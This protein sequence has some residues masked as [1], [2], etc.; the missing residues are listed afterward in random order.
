MSLPEDQVRG[1]ETH[2]I[3]LER[4]Y[5]LIEEHRGAGRLDA[6][7]HIAHQ[8][9][10]ARPGEAR[11]THY[12]GILAHQRGQ[13]G[14]AIEKVQR[15]VALAPDVALFR[16]NL[17]EMYRLAGK[18]DL[19][20]QQGERAVELQPDYAEALSN[21]G[22]AYYERKDYQEALSCQQRAV[23]LK[24]DFGKGHMNLGNALHALR[25]F[26]EALECYDRAV[27][28]MP[29]FADAWAN[30]GTT[31]HHSGR[32][33]EAI[34]ALRRAIAL[35]PKS[36]NA[37]SGLGI[38]LLMRGDLAEGWA[39]YEW[40]LQSTEVRQPYHP[41]RPW[42]G[43]SLKGRHIYI[44]AEQGFGDTI[45]FARYVPLVAARGAKV[46]FRVQQALAGL[47]RQ[48]FP[49]IDIL[50][51]R[52]APAG[53][54]D[55]E[56]ALLSLPHI[57]G[58]RL[59]TIPASLSYL[60]ADDQDVATWRSEFATLPGLKV[61]LVWAGNPE[62]VNDMRRSIPLR[63][64]APLF[65]IPQVSFVSLQVGPGAAA[66]EQHPDIKISDLGAR[67]VT[68][69]AT[70]AVISAL[71]LVICIDSSVAHLSGALG[72]PTWLFM[73]WV[74]D[75]R[76]FLGREDTPW[77]PTMR[78]FRQAQGQSWSE[79]AGRV[80]AELGRAVSGDVKVLSPYR[81]IG[82]KRAAS[83]ASIIAAQEMRVVSPP[84][85][86][87]L[88]PA[89]FLALA[90]QRRQAGKLAEAEMLARRVLDADPKNAEAWHLLGIIA[91]QSGNLAH[92]IEHVKHA[93][94]LSPTTGLYHTNL[95]DMCRLAGSVDDAISSSQ[96]ALEL[97]PNNVGALNN[98]GIA[99]YEK[100]EYEKAQSHYQ[101]AV[102][103][104][105]HFVQ[106]HSNLGNA[107]RAMKR[108]DEAVIHY[109]RAIELAPQFPDAWNNLGTTLRDLK[110]LEEAEAA[111]RKALA[112]KPDDPE[113]LNSLA[114]CVKDLRRLD[115]AERL[116]QRS[117]AI[118]TRN[119]KTLLYLGTLLVELHKVDEA[120]RA[121]DRAL[122][123]DPQN[124][125]IINLMGRVAF[126]RNDLATAET[127]FRQ[128]LE[129]NPGLADAYNNLGNVMKEIGQLD[130]ARE[131]YIKSLSLDP[132]ET[133]VYVNY[134]D[135]VKF[136]ADDPQLRAMETMSSS[137][138][139]LS[140]TERM[141]LAFA[142][143]KAYADLGDHSRSFTHLDK[144]NRLKRAQ[145]EYSESEA[146]GLFERLTRV[147]TRDLVR[148]RT[149]LGG[150]PSAVPIFVFGMPRSGTTLV[151]Q[152]LAS[153][154]KVHGA[155]ELKFLTE[156]LSEVRAPDGQTAP[157]PEFVPLGLDGRALKAIG[158]RYVAKLCNLAPNSLRVT[159]KMP[160][161]FF[162]AGLI[163]L[164]LP[165]ASMIHVIRDPADNCISCY[166][167]LFSD[168]QAFTYDLGELGR[169]YR[170]Y[171]KLMAHWHSV[172]PK[173][174]IL[175]VRYEDVVADLE[176]QARRIIAHCKLDWDDRCLEFHKTRRPVKT[177][178]ASQ[179]RLPIFTNSVGRAA[180]YRE[181]LDTLYA[182]L[183]EAD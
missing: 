3:P 28:L 92:A 143:A 120:T 155:G 33:D 168:G 181:S 88:A 95:G 172:L 122:A 89:Q 86:P 6:A 47:L 56:C 175:D 162:F 39:E 150:E 67:L 125:D 75:W 54:A 153:H 68:F 151:E 40:R 87:V 8:I 72:K 147:F 118:E 169:Y 179:V 113:M 130:E 1:P 21:I 134:S 96:R 35:D 117:L 176:G 41:Q 108:L 5:H 104:S 24:P 160:S 20:I 140:E 145:T 4:A 2:F 102:A 123:L 42:G 52:G 22:I 63:D 53:I 133:G 27:A 137:G 103:H 51:D 17:G 110:Q 26:D 124:P 25:R 106:A 11:A 148:E 107:L 10:E 129:L 15:A 37:H 29:D 70:A 84:P 149:K 180:A 144:A 78:M 142:L 126:E 38:L 91:H 157:Y 99:Y 48:S 112:L 135:S 121:S 64:L 128:A 79:I 34:M 152:I 115:E 173:N 156:V 132:K 77:Y 163:H 80:A 146:M 119:P 19:A 183:E 178:S 136:V 177:A 98:L 46:T 44:H 71:D 114:L 43:E 14:A 131:L 93:I 159:D 97:D 139:P 182:A 13:L 105:P 74:S 45:Q 90:E 85:E 31:L 65:A 116:L 61:G 66:L 83:A 55:C 109:R 73:P 154:G 49:G 30:L 76:W 50:G 167:K 36:A 94:S 69:A 171:A 111:Y 166:S 7:E 82:E 62:H 58:T 16:A 81:A 164:A 165:N 23:A 18:L 158:S 141:H 170:S 127:R 57:F 12:L 60:R 161:N 101:R 100:G 59:E 32:Y 138:V 174:R 9:L